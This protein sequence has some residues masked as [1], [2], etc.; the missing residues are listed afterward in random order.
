MIAHLRQG[1]ETAVRTMSESNRLAEK[2]ISSAGK[3]EKSIADTQQEIEHIAENAGLIAKAVTQ[4]SSATEE[5]NEGM[6]NIKLA[7][8]ENAAGAELSAL[9]SQLQGIINRFK[10]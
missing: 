10:L 8:T 7:A 4:Q 1:T 2:T 9:S 6:Q 5:I 3:S